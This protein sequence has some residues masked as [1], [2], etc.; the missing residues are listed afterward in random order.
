MVSEQTKKLWAQGDAIA[1]AWDPEIR[2]LFGYKFYSNVSIYRDSETGFKRADQPP[3]YSISKA[4]PIHILVG[5]G[6]TPE[7]AIANTKKYLKEYEPD[8]YPYMEDEINQ[9]PDLDE[10]IIGAKL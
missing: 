4:G 8:L 1:R 6:S 5:K 7:E 3:E 2:S 10:K 9:E